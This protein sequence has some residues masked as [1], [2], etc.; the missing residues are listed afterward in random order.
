VDADARKFAK[1]NGLYVIGIHEK[2]DKLLID[3]PEQ[4]GE[5]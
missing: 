1:K 4:C 5:W 3:A 2:E